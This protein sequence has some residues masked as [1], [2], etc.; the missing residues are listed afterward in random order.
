MVRR[1]KSWPSAGKKHVQSIELS[2]QLRLL[3]NNKESYTKSFYQSD[4]TW[5]HP[6]LCLRDY[7]REGR[8][9]KELSKVW[10]QGRLPPDW[11]CLLLVWNLTD[12]KG[13]MSWDLATPSPFTVQN[14]PRCKPEGN[15]G[16][17]LHAYALPAGNSVKKKKKKPHWLAIPRLSAILRHQWAQQ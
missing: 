1:I 14:L 13:C 17:L 4:L 15:C 3:L 2:P 6:V 9:W 5:S 7:L 8:S 12:T 10:C 16:M 11:L